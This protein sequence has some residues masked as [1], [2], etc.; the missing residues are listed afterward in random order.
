L[1][2]P[3]L[4]ACTTPSALS[5]TPRPR[6]HARSLCASSNLCKKPGAARS[7]ASDLTYWST[8][9][10]LR[11]RLTNDRRAAISFVPV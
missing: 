7:A 9:I 6:A 10:I 5:P 11:T 8:S 2:A 1:S 4:S 3:L